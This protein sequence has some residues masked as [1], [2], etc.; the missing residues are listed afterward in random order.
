MLPVTVALVAL[1]G[2]LSGC[3]VAAA[4]DQ[5]VDETY[6]PSTDAPA[7]AAATPEPDD[8]PGPMEPDTLLVI[9]AKAQSGSGA[10]LNLEV[11]V[12]SA[13]AWDDIATQT[14]AQAVIADCPNLFT[15]TQFANESWSF[16]RVNLFV[17]PGIAGTPWPVDQPIQ[18]LPSG[19]T[20]T[21]AARG[22]V[23]ATDARAVPLCRQET[24][25]ST[26]GRGSLALAIPGD[27]GANE[28]F[29]RWADHAYGFIAPTGVTLS[30]CSFEVTPLGTQFGGGTASWGSVDDGHS[31][32]TGSL[33]EAQEY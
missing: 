2:V 17:L 21:T 6:T 32:V 11:R 13:K 33:V 18:L 28:N 5:S 7:A 1:T 3:T 15:T 26:F 10:T 14:R 4:P 8:T 9:R 31:C 30:E 25:F 24:F 27:A 22:T 29:T 16:T 20:V 23:S 19:K 12:K